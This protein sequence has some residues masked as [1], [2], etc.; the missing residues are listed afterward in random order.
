MENSEDECWQQAPE[1][2]FLSSPSGL[3]CKASHARGKATPL[4]DGADGSPPGTTQRRQ[5]NH[6]SEEEIKSK[7]KK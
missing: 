5:L 1:Q 6:S 7:R 2:T 3:S 4:L